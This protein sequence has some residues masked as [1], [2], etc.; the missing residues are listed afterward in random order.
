[1]GQ[2]EQDLK[3]NEKRYRFTM[4]HT[5]FMAYPARA[6]MWYSW[7]ISNIHFIA[8]STEHLNNTEQLEWLENDLTEANS[9]R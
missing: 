6:P 2:R 8:Y 5:D 9:N 1:M 4:P 3:K 7:D